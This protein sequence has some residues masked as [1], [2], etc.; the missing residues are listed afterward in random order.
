MLLGPPPPLLMDNHLK[1]M[2]ALCHLDTV[3]LQ[4]IC[5]SMEALC[6]ER[7]PTHPTPGYCMP[8][9]T[10]SPQ[11]VATNSQ[12][13]QEFLWA[14]S[15]LGAVIVTPPQLLPGQHPVGNRCSDPEIENA[16]ANMHRHKQASHTPLTDRNNNP[17]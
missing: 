10:D 15:N 13:S 11:G 1:M 8:Q 14:A 16:V 5:E 9:M 6:R 12:M 3:G 7:M 17:Q 4:F 2:D